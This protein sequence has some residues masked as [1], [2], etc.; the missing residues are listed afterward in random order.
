[1]KNFKL[2]T[3][4]LALLKRILK[5]PKF[6]LNQI[7]SPG[8]TL[9]KTLLL[10]GAWRLIKNFLASLSIFLSSAFLYTFDIFGS[11][12]ILTYLFEYVSSYYSTI[13]G[14]INSLLFKDSEKSIYDKLI[15]QVD[16][17]Q[18][19][20]DKIKENLTL[21]KKVINKED[22]QLSRSDYKD[23]ISNIIKEKKELYYYLT[24]GLLIIVIS[25]IF[26]P[27]LFKFF[28][29]GTITDDDGPDNGSDES[30]SS[31]S[32]NNKVDS[33][34][35]KQPFGLY[36]PEEKDQLKET[37]TK[38]KG[39][40]KKAWDYINESLTNSSDEI[41]VWSSWKQEDEDINKNFIVGL[42]PTSE[43]DK[44]FP[45]PSD[46]KIETNNSVESRHKLLYFDQ[47]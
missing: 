38:D 7:P 6:I 17:A 29:N 12:D 18:D 34:N 43:L 5:L 23:T 41:K 45:K 36:K 22:S 10:A 40:N 33:V 14:Y 1:M 39:K 46:S 44:Y 31:N 13:T 8:K 4:L 11:A 47:I 35:S 42:K 16:H 26:G 30:N 32:N 21:N 19:N 37:F 25:F 27:D 2:S 15:N 3:I 9:G 28:F 20:L 24:F